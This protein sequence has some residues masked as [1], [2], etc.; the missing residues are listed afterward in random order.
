MTITNGYCT[1]AEFKAYYTTRGGSST[2]TDTNDDGVAEGVIEGASRLIDRITG[3]VFYVSSSDET[4]YFTADDKE[5]VFIDDLSSITSLKVDDDGDRSY[6]TTLSSTDYDLMPYNSALVGWPYTW[7]ELAPLTDESFTSY[8]KGIE[9]VGKFGFPA[10]PDDINE[11][12]LGITLN[13]YN[14]RSGQS[15]AGNVSVTAAGVIIRPSGVPDW[16][17]KI[18]NKY[19]KL[20]T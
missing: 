8:R 11:A 5:T 12:C 17:M 15:S 13:I 18:L 16:A 9:I 14:E 2:N 10:V 20:T 1:L 6:G 19:K 7:I 3:R 4:R